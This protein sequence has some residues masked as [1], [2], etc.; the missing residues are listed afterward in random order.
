MSH[1]GE[2]KCTE[3][4]LKMSQSGPINLAQFWAHPDIHASS[5]PSVLE[6]ERTLVLAERGGLS[7]GGGHTEVE[8]VTAHADFRLFATMNPGGDFGKKEVSGVQCHK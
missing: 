2:P 1:F 6:P 5:V 4:D 8:S 7:E 3:T